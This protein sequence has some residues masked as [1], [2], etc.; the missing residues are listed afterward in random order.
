MKALTTVLVALTTLAVAG[1]TVHSTEQ[2]PLSGPSG[3]AQQV[4][5]RAT[6]DRINQDGAS[7]SS[8]E[9]T[10]IGPSGQAQPGV[11]IRMDMLVNGQLVDF[12][13][14]SARTIVTGTDGKARAIYTAPPAAPATN[15]VANTVS[16]RAA[17]LGTDAAAS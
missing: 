17:P 2:P 14:L 13:T 10:V 3:L 8:I 1:C 7:Q 6:P 5:L 4:T 9:V 12:G 11:A 15:Q 16:I